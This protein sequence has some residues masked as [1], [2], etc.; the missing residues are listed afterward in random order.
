M[1]HH[2]L[3]SNLGYFGRLV[4]PFE[5]VAWAAEAQYATP[6]PAWKAFQWAA[7]LGCEAVPVG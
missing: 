6:M 1:K 4:G 7:A 3:R 5:Y 2:I